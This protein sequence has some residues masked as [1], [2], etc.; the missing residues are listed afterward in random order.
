MLLDLPTPIHCK[1]RLS[2]VTNREQMGL[3]DCYVFA[4]TILENRT[5][6]FTCHTE[7]G[8]VYSRLPIWAFQHDNF[9]PEIDHVRSLNVGNIMSLC[10]WG[11][12]GYDASIIEHA[13]LK[14]YEA[15]CKIE[16]QFFDG[17]YLF[18]IDYNKGL[19]AQ[20]PEQHKTHNIFEL[21]TGHY[22]A[23]PNNHFKLEDSHFTNKDTNCAHYRR[24]EIYWRSHG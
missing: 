16:D 7:N 19:Y 4:V 11:C 20:D 12:L 22:C 14:D 9:N 3:E 15:S 1:V 5:L 8:A 21:E 17:R 18:T 6:L 24:N 13:Y 23:L 2:F 10:P